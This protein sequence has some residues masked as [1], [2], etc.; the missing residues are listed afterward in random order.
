MHLCVQ[1]T[2]GNIL[3]L[4]MPVRIV[5]FCYNC[6]PVQ[7]TGHNLCMCV[8]D[9]VFDLKLLNSQ[10]Y[11][12]TDTQGVGEEEYTIYIAPYRTTQEEGPS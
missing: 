12:H 7:A 6:N 8:C 3:F 4:N 2:V 1:L 9:C 5:Q 10:H 11:I